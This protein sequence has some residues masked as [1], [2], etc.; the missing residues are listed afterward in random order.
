MG[1]TK[2]V[3]PPRQALC[4]SCVLAT[5]DARHRAMIGRAIW[6]VMIGVAFMNVVA[7]LLEA[8]L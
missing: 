7:R 3:L 1:L 5:E 2:E 8:C 4:D 6:F